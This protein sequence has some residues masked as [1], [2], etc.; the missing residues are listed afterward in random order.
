MVPLQLGFFANKETHDLD[1]GLLMAMVSHYGAQ[2]RVHGTGEEV[3]IAFET[4]KSEL[5]HWRRV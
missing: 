2:S 3:R 1:L 4:I 5:K